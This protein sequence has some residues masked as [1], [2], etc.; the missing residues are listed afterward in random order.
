MGAFDIA[1]AGCGPVGLAAALLLHRDHHNVTVFER[2]D[3]PKPVGSGLMIQPTGLAVLDALD[4]GQEV[5]RRGA[6]IDRLFGRA[7][8]SGRT[9]LDFRYAALGRGANYGIGSAR[10]R[11]AAAGRKLYDVVSDMIFATS[12]IDRTM[13]RRSD[14]SRAELQALIVAVGHALMAEQGFARFST[15]E[16][17]KRIGYSV[18]TIYN[19]FEN[20]DALVLAINTCTFALWA[21]HLKAALRDGGDDRIG[22][23]SKAI[24]TLPR[25][26]PICGWRS[27]NIGFSP[28]CRFPKAMRRP[29]LS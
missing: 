11:R 24:S 23:L 9:V 6:R 4:F 18:G 17:A 15:R 1:I 13:G 27:M 5:R 22:R 21:C 2:F 12:D 28:R 26:I 10:E 3:M 25:P 19:M 16:V 8:G 29:A 7:G 20:A 14:H